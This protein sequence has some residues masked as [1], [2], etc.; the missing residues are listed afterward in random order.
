MDKPI[1]IAIEDL[2]ASIANAINDAALPMAIVTPI[3]RDVLT[4]C[5]Q[6]ER[7]QYEMALK[8]YQ[9]SQEKKD[10]SKVSETVKADE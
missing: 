6:L 1:M 2:K 8:E 5:T 4:Q 9:E 7:Q 10:E 3:I